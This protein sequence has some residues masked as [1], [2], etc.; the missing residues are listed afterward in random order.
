MRRSLAD[1][2]AS[3]GNVK[4]RIVN[5]G[6]SFFF[7]KKKQKTFVPLAAASPSTAGPDSQ[8]F[9]GSFFQ[10]RTASISWKNRRDIRS[11]PVSRLRRYHPR[12]R[13]GRQ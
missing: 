13:V 4:S 5:E 7:E 10:K 1:C 11:A 9:F 3:H 2:P 12:R 6:K 8:K